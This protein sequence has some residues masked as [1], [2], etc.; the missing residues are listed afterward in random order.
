MSAAAAS[1]GKLGL[2]YRR[3]RE[4][5]PFLVASRTPSTWPVFDQ[6]LTSIRPAFDQYFFLVAS[7]TREGPRHRGLGS[8]KPPDAAAKV[9][10]LPT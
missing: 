3:I 6:Y 2:R 4:R 5:D 9:E 10:T 1:A 7:R 8:L